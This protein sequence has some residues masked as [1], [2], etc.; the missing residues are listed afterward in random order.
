MDFQGFQTSLPALLIVLAAI[1][2]MAISWWAYRKQQLSLGLRIG[3]ASLRAA[4]LIIILLLLLNPYFYSSSTIEVKPAV[5]VFLDNSESAGIEKGSYNGRNSYENVLQTLNL[6]DSDVVDF[7]FFEIGEE[8]HKSHPD[9]LTLSESQ[10]N[11]SEAVNTVLEFDE[12]IKAAVFVTDGIITYGKNPVFSAASSS[13]PIHTIAIGDTSRIKDIVITNVLTNSTGYTNTTQN[14]DVEIRQSGFQGS[15]IRVRLKKDD[16]VLSQQ[17]V[18]FQSL[19]QVKLLQ[20]ELEFD[21]AGLQQFEVEADILEDEWS[22]DNNDR[23]FSVDVLDSKVKIL[24][25]AFEIHPDVKTIRNIINSDINNELTALTWL[26]GGRYIEDIPE[27]FDF[28]LAVIQ[29]SPLSNQAI[30]VL[31]QLENIPSI[32]I[33]TPSTLKDSSPLLNSFKLIQ[34]D[35]NQVVK[36]WLNPILNSNEHPILELPAV[37][38][39]QAP[40]LSI[41]LRSELA[42]SGSNTLYGFWYSNVNL[43]NPVI[44]IQQLGNIRRTHITAWDWFRYRQS[45]LELHQEFVIQLFSNIISWT[46]S[47]P[48]DQKLEIK[49]AKQTFSTNEKPVITA[50]LKNESGEN[51]DD[52]IIEVEVLND[53]ALSST[54]NMQNTGNGSYRL[55]LPRYAEGLYSFKA[56]ARKGNRVIEEKSGEFLVANSNT[57]LSETHRNDELLRQISNRTKGYFFIFDHV[58]GF[59]DSLRTAGTLEPQTQTIEKYQYPV[60]SVY[61]F[62]LVLSL[63]TAEWLLRKYYSLS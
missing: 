28:D 22:E 32:Y 19:N 25:L 44:A 27:S 43:N 51:E 7:Q 61:W 52:A 60:R 50:T 16:E 34:H 47:N 23:F 3:L 38:L 5:A 1:L 9:S 53:K 13:I 42:Q 33:S 26:G 30:Q 17:N 21:E 31:E 4:S 49:P 10:T 45:Q 15:E 8:T 39:Q 6:E 48:E 41:P 36:A 18:Q 59:W 2:F 11:L 57:E 24:H 54:F 40:P 63:L 37:N 56:V 55:E 46:A 29:G 20:F 14:V 35:G 62:I 58:D 12:N